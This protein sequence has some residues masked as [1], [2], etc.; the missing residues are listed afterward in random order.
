MSQS[1]QRH[2]GLCHLVPG[3]PHLPGTPLGGHTSH[4]GRQAR[5]IQ[6]SNAIV[7]MVL[8]PLTRRQENSAKRQIRVQG[9]KRRPGRPHSRR[10]DQMGIGS[11]GGGNDQSLPDRQ[12]PARLLANDVLYNTGNIAVG[13]ILRLPNGP[14]QS[15]VHPAETISRGNP[16]RTLSRRHEIAGFHM[17]WGIVKSPLPGLN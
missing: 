7:G 3:G 17:Y 16:G 4:A 6:R 13:S 9:P 2:R 10:H 14:V 12:F 1:R 8:I 5:A 15:P 11:V